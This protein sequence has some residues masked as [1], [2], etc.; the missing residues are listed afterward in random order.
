MT[1]QTYVTVESKPLTPG[2]STEITATVTDGSLHGDRQPLEGKSVE[3]VAGPEPFPDEMRGE[4]KDTGEPHATVSTNSF[5]QASVN[6]VAPDDGRNVQL[7]VNVDGETLFSSS[8]PIREPESSSEPYV[9]VKAE[10]TTITLD[11]PD[12]PHINPGAITKVTATVTEGWP[13]GQPLEGK[14]VKFQLV[15]VHN[16]GE[17]SRTTATTDNFGKA[18]VI[19]KAPSQSDI[20]DDAYEAVEASVDDLSDDVG[21]ITKKLD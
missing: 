8:I 21:I 5:G 11:V 9:I 17:L 12:R 7:R 18:S 13:G 16:E 3:F 19:Y 4:F 15:G 2:K 14:T 10:D 20:D 6:Y 1:N